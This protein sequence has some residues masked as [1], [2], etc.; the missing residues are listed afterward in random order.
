MQSMK[1]VR[2]DRF[3]DNIFYISEFR[4]ENAHSEENIKADSPLME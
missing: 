1:L 3:E 2:E 4:D